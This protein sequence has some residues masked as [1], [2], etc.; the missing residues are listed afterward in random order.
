MG[1]PIRGHGSSLPNLAPHWLFQVG[2]VPHF[3]RLELFPILLLTL[4][5]FIVL[6]LVSLGLRLDSLFEICHAL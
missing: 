5:L 2:A 4:A 6:L 3:P 1:E